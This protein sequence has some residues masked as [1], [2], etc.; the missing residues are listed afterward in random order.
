MDARL[1]AMA[2][3]AFDAS[4]YMPEITYVD[5]HMISDLRETA[6]EAHERGLL[7]ATKW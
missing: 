7:T 6:K 1:F 4:E 5:A 2:Q 3:N